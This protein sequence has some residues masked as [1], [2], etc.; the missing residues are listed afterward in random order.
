M[1]SSSSAPSQSS[2]T[3]QSFHTLTT[4]HRA[5]LRAIEKEF[6]FDKM[7][8]V[9][10]KSLPVTLE[11]QKDALV[12]AKTG[13]GK[14]ISFLIPAIQRAVTSPD[15]P[16]VSCLIISPTRELASQIA[17]EASK[18]TK[19]HSSPSFQVVLL[20]G[21]VPMVKDAQKLAGKPNHSMILVATPGRLNDHIKNTPD[22]P[23]LLQGVQTFVLDEFD[24][25]L[26]MGFRADIQKIVTCL[27]KAE[28]RQTLLFSATFP[29]AI[30]STAR[31][32]VKP[33]YETISCVEDSEA[34]EQSTLNLDI[35]QDYLQCPLPDLFPVLLTVIQEHMQQVS[36]YKIIVFFSTARLV[37]WAAALFQLCHIP[38]LEI[39][40]R[41]KQKHRTQTSDHFRAG[42]KVILFSSDVSA[43]GLD[44]PGV[45]LVV[46]LGVPSSR[47]QYVHRIGRTARGGTK[48]EATLILADFEADYFLKRWATGLP[49]HARASVPREKLN[50]AR[51]G[52]QRAAPSV[53]QDIG[54][55]AYSSFLG[56]YLSLRKFPLSKPNLV[57]IANQ[58]ARDSMFMSYQPRLKKI[59][60][61]KM[62][63]D[64][65]PGILL[66]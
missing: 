20:F 33:L 27:P 36:D 2:L 30:L 31:S 40:S 44:Y 1:L 28:V 65:V 32:L 37:Q 24:T 52:I 66:A 11:Q 12:Q 48:G 59:A 62:Q 63:L 50:L 17:V 47:E 34:V 39:H 5:T 64:G 46:Q 19:F 58:L 18:L 22:F 16:R 10:A 45:S 43:R 26:D 6:Q 51:N 54:G 25:L 13:S 57:K 42:N 23:T 60:A 7:T 41:K 38:V 8:N 3:L 56:F 55:S 14:T 53:D 9:Q 49:L 61:K 29:P 15:R 4:L 35:H 21:G